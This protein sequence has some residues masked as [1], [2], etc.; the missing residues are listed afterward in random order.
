MDAHMRLR[1]LRRSDLLELNAWR[2]DREVV[3]GLGSHFAFVGPEVDD[4][5]FSAY[6]ASRRSNIRLAIVDDQPG[7]TETLI[8]CI[9][10]LDISWVARSAE[11][12]LMIG[13]KD[14][15]NRG[16]GS[17]AT[18]ALLEHAFT[19]LGLHRIWLRVNVDNAPARRVYSGA[20]FRVEGTLQQACFKEGKYVDVHL[21]AILADEYARKRQDAAG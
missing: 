12:A 11:L 18:A 1:E 13:R 5:W 10:L 3:A 8:G 17:R 9:Y 14:Y 15:W 7:S 20:G 4:A 6:L 21:M 2:N 16:I 19:D